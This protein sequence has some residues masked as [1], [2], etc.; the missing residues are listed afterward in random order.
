M[1]VAIWIRQAKQA[2]L[3][4]AVEELN[5]VEEAARFFRKLEVIMTHH[6]GERVLKLLLLLLGSQGG[7]QLSSHVSVRVSRGQA[8]VINSTST[9][10]AFIV[11][12]W[13]ASSNTCLSEPR[14]GS[15][16]LASK[17]PVVNWH[18][19]RFSHSKYELAA[20]CDS[21]SSIDRASRADLAQRL[22]I[23]NGRY[24]RK[25]SSVNITRISS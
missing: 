9:P 17:D 25:G 15:A 3:V 14:S 16:E 4:G 11:P 23:V 7:Y 1:K 8:D 10:F 2:S 6:F 21:K 24:V 13:A 19:E 5:Q 18:K 20:V 12:S 22:A